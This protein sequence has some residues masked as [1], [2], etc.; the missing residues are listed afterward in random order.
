[1]ETDSMIEK[2]EW[3]DFNLHLIETLKVQLNEMLGGKLPKDKI[4]EMV[5][6]IMTD[7]GTV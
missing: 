5:I 1:M 6:Q 3:I 2:M 7:N 4:N